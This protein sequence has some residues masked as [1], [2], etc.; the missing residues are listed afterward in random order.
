MEYAFARSDRRLAQ[1]DL[2]PVFLN[3][4]TAASDMCHWV[5]HMNWMLRMLQSLP[6]RLAK[7][8]NPGSVSHGNLAPLDVG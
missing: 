8:F 7:L 5:L 6:V 4:L 2:D 3:A 1:P